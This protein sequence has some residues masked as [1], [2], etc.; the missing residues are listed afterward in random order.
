MAIS[1]KATK[2][3]NHSGAICPTMVMKTPY[4]RNKLKYG[5]WENMRNDTTFKTVVVH[6]TNDKEFL[7]S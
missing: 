7:C 3:Q 1:K 5:A 6:S 2:S 4:F